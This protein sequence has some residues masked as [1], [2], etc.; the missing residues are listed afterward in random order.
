M[1]KTLAEIQRQIATLKREAE[2]IRETEVAEVIARIKQAIR[3]YGLSA[4]D[5]GFGGAGSSKRSASHTSV[6]RAGAAKYRDPA[7]GMTWTGRGRRPQWFIDAIAKGKAPEDL[8][9]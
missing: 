3:H 8:A 9:I 4:K 7:T 6:R 5:L 1:A 2:R